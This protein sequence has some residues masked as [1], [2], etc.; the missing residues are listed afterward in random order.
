MQYRTL[1]MMLALATTLPS[2][3]AQAAE[4]GGLWSG[5]ALAMSGGRAWIDGS[6][7]ASIHRAGSVATA[8]SP[9]A[10]L[11]MVSVAN[12]NNEIGG[13]GAQLGSGAM[14]APMFAEISTS[15]VTGPSFAASNRA[16]RSRETLSE[17]QTNSNTE[18][19]NDAGG[20]LTLL[21]GISVIGFLA[22]K[23]GGAQSGY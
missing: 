23:R 22:F 15:A 1:M 3:A 8:P 16:V 18:P 10:S 2:M 21:A 13:F 11:A 17:A 20:Y 12:A 14:F 5:K 4:V 6:N 7:Y 19:S 9:S